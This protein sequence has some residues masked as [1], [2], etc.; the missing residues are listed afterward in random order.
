M[1]CIIAELLLFSRT[2]ALLRIIHPRVWSCQPS[3]EAEMAGVMHLLFK[4]FH[5]NMKIL[6]IGKKADVIAN[7]ER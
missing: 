4:S 3:Q 7:I 5:A 2:L 6:A 1:A